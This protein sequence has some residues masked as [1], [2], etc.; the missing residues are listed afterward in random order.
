[1]IIRKYFAYEE[2]IR[3]KSN[4][5][6]YLAS[7]VD[8]FT[9]SDKLAKMEKDDRNIEKNNHLKYEKYKNLSI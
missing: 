2:E 9:V 5:V 4:E 3:T 7:D 8:F 1:M 6:C